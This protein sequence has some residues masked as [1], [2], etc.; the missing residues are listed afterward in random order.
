MSDAEMIIRLIG[1]STPEE[2]SA[3]SRPMPDPSDSRDTR[4]PDDREP[5]KQDAD[6]R[7]STGTSAPADPRRRTDP[8][9]TLPKP[10]PDATPSVE[11]AIE[12]IRAAFR[13]AAAGQQGNSFEVSVAKFGEY[14]DQLVSAQSPSNSDSSKP[15]VSSGATKT[16]PQT[17]LQRLESR[18]PWVKRVANRVRQLRDSGA[19]RVRS[20]RAWAATPGRTRIGKAARSVVS[21]VLGPSTAQAA[22]GA[23]RA[24]AAGAGA[25]T[26]GAAGGAAGTAGAG[27]IAAMG[28]TVG[29]VTAGLAALGVAATSLVRKFNDAADDIEKYSADV[30]IARS[31]S[32][33]STELNM[34]DRAQRIGPASGRLEAAKGA[35]GNQTEKL[36]TDILEIVAKA[37]PLMTAGVNFAEATAIQTR[38]MIAIGERGL[39]AIELQQAKLT[40]NNKEDDAAAEKRLAAADEKV[41]SLAKELASKLAQALVGKGKE[42]RPAVD[43]M[44]KAVLDAEFDDE[45]N[46][47]KRK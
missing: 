8:P 38:M 9:L 37:E 11:Q 26:G 31:R 34:L 35:L 41:Q 45:G 30:S 22:T 3:I 7:S 4:R 29:A 17:L 19:R 27:G 16:R 23:T 47:I 33:M 42:D 10:E 2:Q 21:R 43:P 25:A 6:S 15:E 12:N 46:L 18:S 36:L 13:D 44:L 1:D 24:A 39:A 40:E 28:V 5:A 32:R 14:V 20:M